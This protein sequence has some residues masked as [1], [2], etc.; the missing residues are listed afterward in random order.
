MIAHKKYRIKTLPAFMLIV[1]G[2]MVFSLISACKSTTPVTPSNGIITQLNIVNLS[3]DMGG[4]YLWSSFQQ[5]NGLFKPYIYGKPSG[6]TAVLNTNVPFQLRTR[7]NIQY[8][9]YNKVLTLNNRYTIFTTGLVADKSQTTI[10]AIDSDAAPSIGRGKV[11][12]VNAS[13]RSINLDLT[14]N[15]T[16]AFTNV[17]FTKVSKYV[18]MPA[19]IY[20]FKV[21]TTGTTDALADLPRFTVQDGK[22]YT[23]YSQGI[24]GRTDSATFGMNIITNR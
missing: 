7:D 2:V 19:G 22:L 20:D 13:A 17:A 16:I 5:Q 1:L 3:P 12:F 15:G 18:E 10:F 21:F 4:L 9:E 8:F 6:Y 23:I 11:R 24:L 14:A